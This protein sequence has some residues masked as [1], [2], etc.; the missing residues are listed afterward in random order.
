MP[1]LA[2]AF[3]SGAATRVIFERGVSRV[4]MQDI[5]RHLF[6]EAHFTDLKL[7]VKV[8]ISMNK[9]SSYETR[10]EI[11]MRRI[12]SDR[13]WKRLF[14]EEIAMCRPLGRGRQPVESSPA[15]R[16]ADRNAVPER[17]ERPI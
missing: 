14:D 3:A 2:S 7:Y 15:D 11:L 8:L 1:S 13:A 17:K 6:P 10:R 4:A 5:V 16:A 12:S 9:K